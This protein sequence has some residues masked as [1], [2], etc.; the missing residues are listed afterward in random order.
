MFTLEID[1]EFCAAHALIIAGR[2]EP[3]HGHNFRV[4]LR[5]ESAQAGGPSADHDGLDSDGLVC[6]FHTVESTLRDVIGPLDGSDLNTTM[7]ANPTAENI[8]RHIAESV[9][10][11]LEPTLAPVARVASCTVSEAPGCRATYSRG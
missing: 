7:R 11:R 6:D 9:A 8:A 3:V 4:T 2:S 1:A 5:V 10:E